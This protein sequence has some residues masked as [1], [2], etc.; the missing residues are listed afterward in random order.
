MQSLRL[1][2]REILNNGYEACRM[3]CDFI[4]NTIQVGTLLMIF[5][6]GSTMRTVGGVLSST[7]DKGMDMAGR[8]RVIMDRS[9]TKPY[10]IR[11]YLLFRDRCC[12]SSRFNVF[13]HKIIKSDDDD[14]HDHPWGY[15]TFIMSGGYWETVGDIGTNGDGDDITEF[16]TTRHWRD[17]GFMQKVDDTHIHRLEL[18]KNEDTGQDIPCWSLFIAFQRTRDWGFYTVETDGLKWTPA[19]E[20][21]AGKTCTLDSDV[22]DSGPDSETETP[23]G[24]ETTE[25]GQAKDDDVK[26]DADKKED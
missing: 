13:I 19:V 4:F 15:F 21:N 7:W 25:D 26:D 2:D 17:R 8:K 11:Y 16:K 22:S 18:K 5:M 6:L 24:V 1:D 10:M 9:G 20:Y 12:S 23:A 3:F 14:L